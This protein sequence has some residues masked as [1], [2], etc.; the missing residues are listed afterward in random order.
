MKVVVCPQEQVARAAANWYCVLMGYFIRLRPFVPA[1][2][3]YFKKIWMV[4]GELQVLS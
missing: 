2:T 3:N 4:K 1:L